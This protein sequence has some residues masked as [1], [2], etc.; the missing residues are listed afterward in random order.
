VLPGTTQL[1]TRRVARREFLLRPSALTSSLFLYLLAVAAVE[2]GIQ[3]HAFCV[4]SNHFH[5]LLT[6][7]DAR[8]PRFM[9]KLDALLAR[10]LNASL[11]RSG[12]V[13]EPERSYS[14]VTPV[15]SSDVLDKTV[16]VLANPVSAGLVRNGRE[17]PGPW[18]APELIGTG[19]RTLRRPDFFFREDGPLPET[20]DLELTTPPG[21][22]SPEAFRSALVEAL[23]AR[24]KE[25]SAEMSAEGRAFLGARRVLAQNPNSRPSSKQE[26][27][28]LNPSIAGRDKWKRIEALQGLVEFRRAYREA[29]A[30][31][32]EGV[33]ALFPA[34]TYWLRVAHG[35][36]CAPA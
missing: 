33:D 13:W 4:M 34:G 1:V 25:I 3:L 20:V 19:S 7:P 18:S 15:A 17:W 22:E 8:L 2:F 35:V 6:D 27:G 31:L 23:A 11:G 29:P 30:K 24:E 14:A 36:R 28:K 26:L 5:L 21:F 32:R 9:Q 16:Y 10:A 12:S